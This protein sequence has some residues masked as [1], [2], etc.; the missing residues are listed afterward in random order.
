LADPALVDLAIHYFSKVPVKNE[1]LNM[2]LMN[3][4]TQSNPSPG[5]LS[6]IDLVEWRRAKIAEA[7]R[8]GLLSAPGDVK[9]NEVLGEP[10]QPGAGSA[11]AAPEGA[12]KESLIR[13][14]G[15][16]D[17]RGISVETLRASGSFHELRWESMDVVKQLSQVPEAWKEILERLYDLGFDS[18]VGEA[19][20]RVKDADMLRTVLE[21]F[22]LAR[23]SLFR[24]F[25]SGEQLVDILENGEDARARPLV[26]HMLAGGNGTIPIGPR[27]RLLLERA[28]SP[29]AMKGLGRA[30]RAGMEKPV[31]PY[32]RAQQAR[33]AAAR[34]E[35]AM[36]GRSNSRRPIRQPNSER[37][38]LWK[39][40][41]SGSVSQF[42]GLLRMSSRMRFK[43]ASLRMTGS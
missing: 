8:N 19:I 43:S 20:R 40:G 4:A 5:K 36:V 22:L 39:F 33:A 42:P 12:P 1:R 35:R 7:E 26:I 29:D 32:D 9:P 37:H 10:L 23:P 3:A 15:I 31:T 30:P 25:G 11:V 27:S 2:W 17:L 34:F 38:N 24:E 13:S 6:V 21:S 16:K 28:D 41:F 14:L 18:P